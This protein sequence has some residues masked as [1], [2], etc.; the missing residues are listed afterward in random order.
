MIVSCILVKSL[1][2]DPVWNA[3][4]YSKEIEND[5]DNVDAILDACYDTAAF[6]DQNLLSLLLS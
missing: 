4:L 6:T 1:P 5:C 2:G 3:H